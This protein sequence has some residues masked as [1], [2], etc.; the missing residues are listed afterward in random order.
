METAN[1][2]ETGFHYTLSLISEKHKMVILYCLMEF[3]AGP[4]QLCARGEEN[5]ARL[6]RCGEKPGIFPSPPRAAA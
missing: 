5:M 3:Q 2:E 1:F 6:F 4:D